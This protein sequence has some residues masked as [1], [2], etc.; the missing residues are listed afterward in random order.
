MWAAPSFIKFGI[1]TLQSHK[2]VASKLFLYEDGKIW[3]MS[4]GGLKRS[5]VNTK[6]AGIEI[7][8]TKATKKIGDPAT[9]KH[10]QTAL[11]FKSVITRVNRSAPLRRITICDQSK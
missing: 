9:K 1:L 4:P 10:F 3:K 5:V 6:H 7:V 2:V 8:A 11:K